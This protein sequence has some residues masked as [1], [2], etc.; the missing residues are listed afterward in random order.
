MS[1]STENRNRAHNPPGKIDMAG[2]GGGTYRIV[3]AADGE[4][5]FIEDSRD[6][7]QHPER[8]LRNTKCFNNFLWIK[9]DNGEWS[10]YSHM[11]M[12][13]STAKAGRKVGERV[14]AGMYL[15]D[16]GKVGCAWPAHLHFEVVV[17]SNA[18]PGVDEASGEVDGYDFPQARNPRFTDTEGHVFTFKDGANYVAGGGSTK[19][20][21]DTD[22]DSGFY[23]NTGI[24]LT[25]NS[26]LPLKA[27]N[28]TCELVGGGHQCKSGQCKFSRCYTPQSVSMGNTCYVND[29]CKAGKC[30]DVEGVKGTCV[31]QKDAD[32]DS[33]QYCD[34][35]LDFK[36][37]ACRAKLNKG[38]TCGKAGSVGN[39]HKCKSGQCSG[40]PKYECK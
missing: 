17:P 26:C 19:C 37:N 35:G 7:Q 1:G 9:H 10:K 18:N 5:R 15:G 30:S 3:A 38:T 33:D 13:T 11:Q 27:D 24:D 14:T 16:E 36:I 4:I 34:E 29:A 32:C 8:W 6:K 31:C 21:K 22:C 39:D 23:C 2:R 12:G 40:F 25:K 20:Q 28:E